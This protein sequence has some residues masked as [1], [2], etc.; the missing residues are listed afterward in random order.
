MI[1]DTFQTA[2]SDVELVVLV[3]LLISGTSSLLPAL[4]PAVTIV[5]LF[6][7]SRL[8]SDPLDPWVLSISPTNSSGLPGG[9]WPFRVTWPMDGLPWMF[10]VEWL[11]V[12]CLFAPWLAWRM[13]C[14]LERLLLWPL[15]LMLK[16]KMKKFI[17]V[18]TNLVFFYEWNMILEYRF[19]HDKSNWPKIINMGRYS[20]GLLNFQSTSSP[21][22]TLFFSSV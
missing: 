8:R 5:L 20:S 2:L 11:V 22:P 17:I 7:P 3:C 21:S 1:K 14:W 16:R 13:E 4:V 15:C 9:T 6:I 10:S 12:L 19:F 18:V